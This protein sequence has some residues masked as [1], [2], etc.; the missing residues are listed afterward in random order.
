MYLA[1]HKQCLFCGWRFF[2][3]LI[4]DVFKFFKN[5][6]VPTDI[7]YQVFQEFRDTSVLS[8]YDNQ[9]EMFYSAGTRSLSSEAYT[10]DMGMLAPLWLNDQIPNYFVVFRLNDPSAVN[11]VN[12]PL[13]NEGE[14][15]AQTAERFTQFVLQNCT[16]LSD[17]YL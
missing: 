17:R 13:P 10:E 3:S 9:Y 12:A 14:T 16:S 2:L 11:N 8:S 5:G 7:A 6:S 4:Q 15:A 1:Y